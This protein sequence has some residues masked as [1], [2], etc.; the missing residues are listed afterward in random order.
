[1]DTRTRAQGTEEPELARVKVPSDPARL[2][3]TTA[4]FR[5]RLADPV[6]PR[7][8]VPPELFAGAA[9][10]AAAGAR[11]WQVGPVVTGGRTGRRLVVDAQPTLLPTMIRT[12][13]GEA[14][15]GAAAA[16]PVE[17]EAPRR[18]GRVSPI[19]WTG[20]PDS[21]LVDAVRGGV[22]GQGAAPVGAD[23]DTRAMAR[24]AGL[25]HQPGP[26]RGWYGSGAGARSGDETTET[27]L[28]TVRLR[29][30]VPEGA[31][32]YAEYA[33]THGR[34]AASGEQRHAWYPGRRVDLGLVLLPLRVFLGGISIYAGFSKLCDPVYFD[35]GVRG[36][37]MHWLQSLHP[38]EFA[39]PLVTWAESHPVGAGLGV[40]FTQVVVGVLAMLG[41]WTRIASAVA[42]LLALALLLTVSWR[43]VP[44][45]D[46][47]QII[48]LAAWSPLLIAGAPF[49]S[50]DGRL[51]LNAW[52]RYGNSAPVSVQRRRVLRRGAVLSSLVIGATLVAGAL[53]GAAVR[54]TQVRNSVD[55]QQPSV[56]TQY[57]SP[58]W[59]SA[60][61]SPGAGKHGIV[62]RPSA[63]PSAGAPTSAAATAGRHASPS[64]TVTGSGS[65]TGTASS[66]AGA[67]GTSSPTHHHS[68]TARSS[69]APTQSGG[70]G[71][72]GGSAPPS[73]GALGGLLG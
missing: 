69:G 27:D 12:S 64:G 36:S 45:Y 23:D 7:I 16:G 62:H 61:P 58:V 44:V 19:T 60:L 24:I 1:M 35:G 5:L 31:E 33:R 49:F 51:A 28:D 18:P 22:P 54:S 17:T 2:N 32:E 71:G 66:G 41:L 68:G 10:G 47:P 15:V 3:T 21:G 40:A 14:L 26:D 43:S 52:R 50:L 42:M 25:T 8:S 67:T 65:G 20:S 48:Y 11:P 39:Q 55:P 34:D 13:R 30:F 9:A 70:G 4:S 29:A 6:Q 59:P 53:F 57:P 73:G 63:R 38:W 46:A 37:M 56:P 72:G